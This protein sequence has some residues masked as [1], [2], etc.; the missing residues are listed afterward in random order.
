MHFVGGTPTCGDKIVWRSGFFEFCF[1]VGVLVIRKSFSGRRMHLVEA[2]GAPSFGD[3]IRAFCRPRAAQHAR[4]SESRAPTRRQNGGSY[5]LIMCEAVSSQPSAR[6]KGPGFGGR[7][8]VCSVW[9]LGRVSRNPRGFAEGAKIVWKG[10]SFLG[11]L[12]LVVSWPFG[13]C[14][15]RRRRR[16]G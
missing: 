12:L 5:C 10:P 8:P 4:I 11:V 14:D 13:R 3:I 16:A 9:H 1:G 7:G 6:A 2:G 15:R